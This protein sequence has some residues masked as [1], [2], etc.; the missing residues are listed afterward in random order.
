MDKIYFQNEK[1]NNEQK[2]VAKKYT[3]FIFI[4]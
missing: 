3:I 1:Q 4:I 2:K